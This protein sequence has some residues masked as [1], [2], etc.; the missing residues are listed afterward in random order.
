[1]DTFD[2]PGIHARNHYTEISYQLMEQAGIILIDDI[3]E[4][5]KREKEMGLVLRKERR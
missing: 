4:L 5:I 2:I 3:N 1:M